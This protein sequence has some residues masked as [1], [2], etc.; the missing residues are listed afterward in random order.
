M[1]AISRPKS[2][3]AIAPI[4]TPSKPEWRKKETENAD[5]A[6]RRLTLRLRSKFLYSDGEIIH[7]DGV[8]SLFSERR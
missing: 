3:P 5:I 7:D 8:A 4:A 1:N 2:P 6:E